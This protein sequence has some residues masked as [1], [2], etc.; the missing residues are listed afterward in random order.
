M[1]ISAH[2]RTRESLVSQEHL[3]AMLGLWD[4][5]FDTAKTYKFPKLED[6]SGLA[7]I[8]AGRGSAATKEEGSLSES[9]L[10]RSGWGPARS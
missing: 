7:R 5:G 6:A 1:P 10:G 3:F 4:S 9:C 2:I 8:E